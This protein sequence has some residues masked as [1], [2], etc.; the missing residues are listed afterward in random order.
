MF[1]AG[2]YF[3]IMQ[4]DEGDEQEEGEEEQ[5]NSEVERKKSNPGDEIAY[6]VIVTSNSGLQASDPT[7]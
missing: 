7:R 4:V 2:E 3:G 1:D 5:E 6:K